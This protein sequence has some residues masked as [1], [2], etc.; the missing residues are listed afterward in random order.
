MRCRMDAAWGPGMV[1][2]RRN[3]VPDGT[4]FFT[5]TFATHD[6]GRRRLAPA[7]RLRAWQSAETWMGG[8]G[9]GLAALVLP[10]VR[11]RGAVAGGLG[12]GGGAPRRLGVWRG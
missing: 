3:R 10:S 11:A 9:A 1:G 7:R 12:R 6:P 8:A 5:V 2:Y 4:F